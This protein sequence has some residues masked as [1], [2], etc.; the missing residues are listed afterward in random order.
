ME[1]YDPT[2]NPDPDKWLAL[3]E[4][5]QINL[6]V[7]FHINAKE[8]A[9]EGGEMLHASFHVVVENQIAMD[10][11][12]VPETITKLIR[13]GLERHE[14]IH[15]VGAVICENV[16]DLLNVTE[17]SWNSKRYRS[18]LEKLTAKRWKKGQW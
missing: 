13:Q 10:V 18:R 1:R 2:I 4:A 9:P 8:E 3:D 12:P 17:K 6:V 16:Y 14:A 7:D 5:E 11:E 15:A